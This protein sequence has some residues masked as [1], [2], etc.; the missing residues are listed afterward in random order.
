MLYRGLAFGF[1]SSVTLG[2]G[3][4]SQAF[5]LTVPPVPITELTRVCEAPSCPPHCPGQGHQNSGPQPPGCTAWLRLS[6]RT[7]SENKQELKEGTGLMA[8]QGQRPAGGAG[9]GP[10][11]QG[12]S[13]GAVPMHTRKDH[14]R[15]SP[16]L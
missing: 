10:G 12:G 16:H 8:R 4:C 3:C 7:P 15:A 1:E 5:S 6:A 14:W 13:T 9:A 2:W 11:A